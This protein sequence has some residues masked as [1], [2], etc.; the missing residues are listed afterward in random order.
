[1]ENINKIDE[2][3]KIEKKL[4]CIE[5]KVNILTVNSEVNKTNISNK[6]KNDKTIAIIS[7]A[8]ITI[9]ISLVTYVEQLQISTTKTSLDAINTYFIKDSNDQQNEIDNLEKRVSLIERGRY[10]K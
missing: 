2:F 1:M 5:N 9:I 3:E 7:W 8:L 6:E 4:D 10:G